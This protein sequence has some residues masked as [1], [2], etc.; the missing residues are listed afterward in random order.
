MAVISITITPSSTQTLPG[1]PDTIALS[2]S[3]PATIFFSLDGSTPDV[4]S[5]IY[6]VPIVMPQNLLTVVLNVFATNGM[7]SSAVI[8]QI[9]STTLEQL[10][11]F[12]SGAR[13]AHSATTNLNNC[14]TG[15]SLFPFGTDSPNT[16]YRY[17]GTQNAGLTVF[18]PAN[19]AT[20]TGFDGN[21]DPSVFVN[22]P[23]SP[24]I[25]FKQVYST[26]N[27]EG[28]VSIGVGNLPAKTRI[29]G[30]SQARE[31]EQEQSS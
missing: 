4:Y 24:K 3:E 31:Y 5:P 19:P 29:I 14:S 27:A 25:T 11:A 18:N 8:T 13:L 7:D 6:L 22:N 30:K 20:S 28:E 15:N 21:G 1:I 17:I 16:N 26:T 12:E 10:P 9:Y 2:T 23:S